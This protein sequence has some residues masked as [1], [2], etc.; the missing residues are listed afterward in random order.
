MSLASSINAETLELGRQ[1]SHC[2]EL[3][4]AQALQR[5]GE[6]AEPL[7]LRSLIDAPPLGRRGDKHPATVGLVVAAFHEAVID[8]GRHHP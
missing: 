4:V 6:V 2:D 1:R 7:L 5:F 8:Q 3:F